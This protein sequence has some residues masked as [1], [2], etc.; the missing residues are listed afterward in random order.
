MRN[1]CIPL[2]IVIIFGSS[3]LVEA[4]QDSI[5]QLQE[6]QVKSSDL[7]SGLAAYR[8]NNFHDAI[9]L[10]GTIDDQVAKLFASK[11]HYALGN[12][13]Q[14]IKIASELSVRP[15]RAVSN[16]AQYVRALAHYQ[17]KEFN[18]SLEL[19]HFLIDDATDS[20]LSQLAESMYDSM[21]RYLSV[22]Q[23]IAVIE[24]TRNEQIIED[25]LR[26]DVLFVI[27]EDEASRLQTVVRRA[28]GNRT[29]TIN[30]TD[31]RA[32]QAPVGTIYRIGVLLPGFNEK[33]EDRL[34][35]RGIYNGLLI[36]ADVFNSTN[37]GKKIELIFT[38]TDT[39][40]SNPGSALTNLIDEHRV[41]FIIGPLFSEQ[42]SQLSHIANRRNT[43]LFAPLANSIDLAPNN[44]YLFQ[45]NPSFEVRG[46]QYA[47]FLVQ[48]RGK[49]RIGVITESNTFGEIEANAF[50]N[51]AEELGAE[52]PLFF[53]EDF[54]RTGYTVSHI[55]PWFTNNVNLIQDT[56]SYRADS[57]DAVFLSFTSD[58]AETLLDNT[59]TGIEAFLPEYTILTNETLSYLDHSIQRIRRLELMYA[60][61][62]Y[63][64]EQREDVTNFRYDYRNRTGFDPSMFSYIG[65]DLGSFIAL[66]LLNHHNPDNLNTHVSS[67]EEF[68]GLATRI[69][70]GAG[71]VNESL[72][73]FRLTTQ[74][75][76]RMSRY[77]FIAPVVVES[78]ELDE[79]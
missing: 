6:Q 35:S 22:N 44:Q 1:F 5:A 24:R 36:A 11:S 9:E 53:S 23:R 57:L 69:Y 3:N 47:Q 62:Y 75:V 37:D 50:R 45:L 56:V 25:L 52:I 65:Y 76:E 71:R 63:L 30:I 34:V 38:D 32:G 67:M 18:L 2:F 74:G 27:D 41:D 20:I 7:Q 15:P 54:S 46:R 13:A 39:F 31:N 33:E 29:N 70:F 48:N 64:S 77:E 61:T 78:D 16:E 4:T 43:P 66:Y 55:L 28:T 73:F 12:Y 72:Q 21:L 42:V 68:E 49:K 58:V 17:L 8:Q 59:L 26:E 10:L 19:L 40:G 51:T 14:A 79:F 60:D